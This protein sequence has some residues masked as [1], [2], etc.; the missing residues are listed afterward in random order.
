MIRFHSSRCSAAGWCAPRGWRRSSRR[1][2]SRPRAGRP[3][4]RPRRAPGS[5]RAPRRRRRAA[6]RSGCPGR[7]SRRGGRRRAAG[8]GLISKFASRHICRRRAIIG[9][10]PRNLTSSSNVAGVGTARRRPSSTAGRPR[11]RAPEREHLRG[12]ASVG[13]RRRRRGARCRAGRRRR[14]R[15]PARP[16]RTSPSRSPSGMNRSTTAVS[17]GAT[18]DVARADRAPSASARPSSL[19]RAANTWTARSWRS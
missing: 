18:V 16:T 14:A 13:C 1:A 5:G 10:R 11:R 8:S 7:R 9:C 15:R 6:R 19:A 3:R 2:R 17:G 12:L 4:G